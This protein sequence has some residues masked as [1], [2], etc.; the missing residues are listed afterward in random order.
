M[1]AAAPL[2]RFIEEKLHFMPTHVAEGSKFTMTRIDELGGQ[3]AHVGRLH[4]QLALRGSVKREPHVSDDAKRR[5]VVLQHHLSAAEE[6][7]N[8]A[9]HHVGPTQDGKHV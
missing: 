7:S 6:T 8:D 9:H 1:C 2:L 4:Q 3:I 5:L